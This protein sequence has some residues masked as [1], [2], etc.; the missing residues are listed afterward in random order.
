[1]KTAILAGAS[2]FLLGLGAP[3]RAATDAEVCK[4]VTDTATGFNGK[5]PHMVDTVTRADKAVVN[6]P[7][8]VADFTLT[9]MLESA[10]MN[11]GWQDTLIGAWQKSVCAAKT[12]SDAVKSGWTISVTW[13]T[14]DK[15]QYRANTAC[16]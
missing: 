10:R 5:G 15:V 3:A 2:L 7:T 16:P 8:R 14:N 6:C 12:L 4:F 13:T 11:T 1:M 9:I